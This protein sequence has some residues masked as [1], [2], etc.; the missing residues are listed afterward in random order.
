M[1]LGAATPFFMNLAFVRGAVVGFALAAPI[2]PVAVLCIRRALARGLF[3][4]L[5]VG[6]GAAL[7]DAAFGAAAG[8]GI[9]VVA[10]FVREYETV[11]GTAG[12]LLVLV[13]G[14]TTYRAPVVVSGCAV[15]VNNLGR[16]FAAAFSMAITNPA[17]MIAA[18]G[19]FAAFG[20]ID[21]GV[22]LKAALWLILGVF[23][24]SAVWWLILAGVVSRLRER[25]I[26]S[27]LPWLNRVSGSV[28]ALSGFLVLATLAMKVLNQSG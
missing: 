5:V 3:Q 23:A 8:L 1:D 6:L 27:G 19:L 25:F 16:D 11:I 9:T 14:V 28:I 4:A 17:T 26:A 21:I 13:L 20:P 22:A 18:V 2:G 10:T 12:G 24:G 7:A 15:A